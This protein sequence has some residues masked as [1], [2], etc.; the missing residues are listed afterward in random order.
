[1]KRTHTVM[2]VVAGLSLGALLA[3][4]AEA[5]DSV[6]FAL[7]WVPTGRDA[8]FYAALDRGEYR[9][10]GL[11]VTILKGNGSGDTVK[12]VA[13]G[14]EEFGFA[15]ATNVVLGRAQGLKVRLV[16]M[17]HDKSLFGVYSLKSAGIRKPKDLEGKRVG[18]PAKSATRT[19]FPAFAGLNGVDLGKVEWVDMTNAA[20]VPS[21]LAGRVDAILIF[22][23]EFPSLRQAAAKQGKEATGLL[24][25][26]YGVDVY[27]NG[28]IAAD[29]TI[30]SRPDLVRR[31]VRATMKGVAWAAEHPE[32]AATIF[33]KH[34]PASDEALALE[35]WKI[36]VEHLAT[37][38]TRKSG[39]G[40]MAREKME[41]TRDLIARFEKLPAPVA[42]EEL[43]TNDFLPKI[44]PR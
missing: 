31:F 34:N 10:E 39:L 17:I 24:F 23:N 30:Q 37:P 8:G 29:A 43:Y 2:L 18:S 15:D 28:L 5:L 6:K 26:D 40:V 21:L 44:M 35:Y 19:V 16:G 27:S 3:G 32:Q 20:M 7:S 11:D 25:S 13:V 38:A 9:E 36:A 12:R 42:T 4:G 22:A 41:A 14:S 1:M 33:V